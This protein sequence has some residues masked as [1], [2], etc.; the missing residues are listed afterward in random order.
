MRAPLAMALW[1]AIILIALIA[2]T[3]PNLDLVCIDQ[4]DTITI[5]T[6]A[7]CTTIPQ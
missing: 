3:R 2:W 5:E 7:Q 4:L 1:A 6:I